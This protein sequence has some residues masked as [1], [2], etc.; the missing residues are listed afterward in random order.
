MNYK[1]I[2][3]FEKYCVTTDGRIIN[4]LKNKSI[5]PSITNSGYY[6]VTLCGNK[7]YKFYVHRLV[8]EAFISNPD[9]KKQI[10][11]IDGNKLN[12]DMSNLEWCTE[13]ENQLHRYR[14]LKKGFKHKKKVIC[15]ETNKIYDDS[16]KAAEDT[17]LKQGHIFECCQG[18][19]KQVGNLHWRFLDD[20]SAAIK[21]T[22]FES[23]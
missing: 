20:G 6:Q 19:R 17:K 4:L 15:L 21:H 3:N 22:T 9:N 11:H 13:S 12:N 1:I 10:N 8:A 7:R 5:V 2:H 18:K 14:V 16:Y 23:L